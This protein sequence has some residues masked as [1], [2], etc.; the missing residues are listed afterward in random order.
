M[1]KLIFLIFFTLL[2]ACDKSSTKK[3]YNDYYKYQKEYMSAILDE[4]KQQQIKVLKKV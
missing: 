1:K 3:A 2:F 4:N